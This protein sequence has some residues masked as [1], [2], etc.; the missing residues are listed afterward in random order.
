VVA[1]AGCAAALAL[2]F[3]G[4]WAGHSATSSP[5]VTASA[6]ALPAVTQSGVTAQISYQG[7]VTGTWVDAKMS[8]TPAGLTCTLYVIDK[9]HN[10]VP[11]SSW[12]SV[13]GKVV[14]IPA[15]TALTPDQID[16]FQVKVD[17]FGYDIVVPMAS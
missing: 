6:T 2:V 8:G 12:K 17:D 9:N 7:Q 11:L 3:G 1:A 4:F 10:A 15:T 14:S 16:H 5:S 13:A